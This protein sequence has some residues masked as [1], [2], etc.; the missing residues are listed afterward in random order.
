MNKFKAYFTIPVIG[1][2]EGV[3]CAVEFEA[4]CDHRDAYDV[5]AAVVAGITGAIYGWTDPA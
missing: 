5:G 3:R 2:N 4:E 1:F